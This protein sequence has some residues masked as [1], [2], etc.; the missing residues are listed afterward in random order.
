MARPRKELNP[1]TDGESVPF[2]GYA[3]SVECFKHELGFTNFKIVTLKIVDGIVVEKH[4]SDPYT[5]WEAIA[6]IEMYAQDATLNLQSGY[7][8]GKAWTK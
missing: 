5:N 7:E 6:R 4:L 3:R 1:L 8:H 2:T